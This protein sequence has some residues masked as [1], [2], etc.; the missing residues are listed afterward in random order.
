M[1]TGNLQHSSVSPPNAIFR[2]SER[3]AVA[4]YGRELRRHTSTEFQLQEALAREGVLRRQIDE[5]IGQQE[6]VCKL[7][8]GREDAA[9]YLASLSPRERHIISLVLAGNP[10]KNIAADLGISIRTV[11]NHR[12]SIM[13]KAGSKSLPA[14]A[15][16]ALAATWNDAGEP[17]TQTGF[18]ITAAR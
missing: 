14:S 13:K 4:T 7:F 6:V 15:R 11:E 18:P 2:S 8:A 9:K 12:A 16:L 3:R 1:T 17:F 10:S 5:L